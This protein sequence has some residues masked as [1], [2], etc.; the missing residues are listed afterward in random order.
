MIGSIQSEYVLFWIEDHICMCGADRLVSIVND[1]ANSNIEYIGYSWFGLGEFLKEFENIHL[2]DRNTIFEINY[3]KSNN[4]LR[5]QNAMRIIDGYSYIISV[6][7]IFSREFFVRLLKSNRP[8]LRRWPKETPFDFEKRWDDQYVLPIRYG[9]P[10]FEIFAAIDDD[11]KHPGSSL[12]SRGLYPKRVS[13]SELL[14]MRQGGSL[15]KRFKWLRSFLK[16]IP[17][18]HYIFKIW[19]RLTY[20]F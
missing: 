14:A 1:M 18:A 11:N 20:Y 6:C 19:I 4:V 3:D 8:F 7:G 10:K 2:K 9:I 15:K 5:Q 13:R 17:L 12:F 16:N